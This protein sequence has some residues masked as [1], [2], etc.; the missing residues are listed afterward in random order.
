MYNSVHEALLSISEDLSTTLVPEP[1]RERLREFAA[2][3]PWLGQTQYLECRLGESEREQVDL[4]ISAASTYERASLSRVLPG[5]LGEAPLLWP[6][7]RFVAEWVSPASPLHHAVP[8]AWLEFDHMEV[9]RNPLANI[10]VCLAPAYIDPFAPLP[11]QSPATALGTVWASLNAILGQTPSGDERACFERCFERLPGAARWIHLSVMTAREPVELKLYGTFP[12]D[13]VLPY[14][15]DI[16][17]RGDARIVSQML[18]RYCSPERTGGVVYVDLP[19]TGML[20]PSRAGLGIVFPKQHLRFTR[21]RDVTRSSL[22]QQLLEDGLCTPGQVGALAVWPGH[23][24]R[25]M[26]TGS[27]AFSA[28]VERWFDVKV[29]HRAA[30]PLLAKAYLG[31][32]ARRPAQATTRRATPE[33]PSR[34]ASPVPPASH[35]TI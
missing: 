34:G 19:V 26:S 4:L 7:Q 6:L 13:L 29:A 21:D 31:F 17:W 23:G 3:F 35:R 25:T 14:L 33:M 20:D 12:P 28:R 24:A 27:G 16:G 22:L 11:P 30:R 9:D 15:E 32:T 10:G 1:T 5:A 2:R 18:A 8:V